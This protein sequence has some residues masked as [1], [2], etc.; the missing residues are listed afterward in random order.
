MDRPLGQRLEHRAGTDDLRGG[1]PTI[2]SSTL[3]GHP[4]LEGTTSQGIRFP[5]QV[6]QK[7]YTLF[8]VARYNPNGTSKQTIFNGS[9]ATFY[10][11]FY[12]GNAGGVAHHRGGWVVDNMAYNHGTDWVLSTDMYRFYRKASRGTGGSLFSP[13]R[14][15][16]NA[17]YSQFSDWQV[18]EVILYHGELSEDKY[19]KVENYLSAKYN[20]PIGA[21]ETVS[22]PQTVTHHYDASRVPRPRGRGIDA[23]LHDP[24]QSRR[25]VVPAA[26]TVEQH[27]QDGHQQVERGRLRLG[28]GQRLWSRRPH[29]L[30]ERRG[31]GRDAHLRERRPRGVVQQG[32]EHRGGVVGPHDPDG[33][34]RGVAREQHPVPLGRVPHRARRA[35]VARLTP[36][37]SPT[38]GSVWTARALC[39]KGRRTIRRSRTPLP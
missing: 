37:T 10:S 1:G 21:A 4:V 20:L 25:G 22:A 27:G 3:N 18:A 16:I 7:P 11:G 6:L 9:G 17:A 33:L 23:E 8:H 32:V 26:G 24:R 34:R 5:T 36:R 12:N 35:G 28:R 30:R 19:T 38:H 2:S 29:R 13:P 39:T 14:L 15:T 31:A